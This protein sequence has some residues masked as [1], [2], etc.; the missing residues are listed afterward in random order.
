MFSI[1]TA[2]LHHKRCKVRKSVFALVCA[3]ALLMPVH[4][5]AVSTIRD[6]EIENMLREY[7]DP[8]FIAAGLQ[9]KAV[10]IHIV[11]DRRI[12]A[13]VANGQQIYLFAGL[14]D[15]MKTPEMIIG[16]VAHETG[17]LAGGHLPKTSDALERAQVPIILSTLLGIGAVAAGAGDVGAAIIAAGQTVGE[18]SFLS[19]SRAQEASADQAALSYLEASGE[20]ARG[21]LEVFQLF[22]AEERAS[23]LDQGDSYA[24]SHP[25]S[26]ERFAALENRAKL[27]PY[28]DSMSEE[29][30]YQY[31]LVRAKLRGF[32]DD[33]VVTMRRYP[34]YDQSDPALYSR[35]V[36][37]YQQGDT[38]RAVEE[39]D[40]LISRHPDNPYFHELRG[41]ILLEGGKIAES[42]SAYD[43]AIELAPDESLILTALGSALVAQEG[44]DENRRAIPILQRAVE[45]DEQNPFAMRQLALA[46]ARDG[47]LG[48]AELTSAERAFLL[49][50]VKQAKLHVQRAMSKL[51]ERSPAWQRARDIQQ[52][53]AALEAKAAEENRRRGKRAP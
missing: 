23:G 29:R 10:K 15:R 50:D 21:L 32:L 52:Q 9:P 12:N 2:I 48:F 11:N 43:K 20:T 8:I 26:Y 5:F 19:Y 28:Y 13:F 42:I 35:S 51:E 30:Q 4:A 16:I 1:I 6:A 40:V 47:R 38:R 18:R 41:Q 17:H 33:P 36:A 49:G 27:S 39:I 31:D 46:Y 22:G 25:L 24:S 44:A 34:D 14:F 37:Y 45:L 3:V 7:S 53:V